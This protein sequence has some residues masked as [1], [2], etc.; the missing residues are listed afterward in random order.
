MQFVWRAAESTIIN[1]PFLVPHDIIHHQT[2]LS[3]S[4]NIKT[5]F[6]KANISVPLM[7][8]SAVA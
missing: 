1:D 4:S 7:I 6:N 8:G 3:E 5:M 2:L